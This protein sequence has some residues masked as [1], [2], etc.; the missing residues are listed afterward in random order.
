MPASTQFHTCLQH[1]K[2]GKISSKFLDYPLI[3]ICPIKYQNCLYIKLSHLFP[4][5][6]F[7]TSVPWPPLYQVIPPLVSP[8][9]APAVSTHSRCEESSP[10][11]L[12]SLQ[13]SA[14]ETKVK[15]Y[16]MGTIQAAQGK[17]LWRKKRIQP[18]HWHRGYH[19][20]A[21]AGWRRVHVASF[22]ALP[23]PPG[24]ARSG[25]SSKSVAC[26]SS[27]KVTWPRQG[28]H[29]RLQ[30]RVLQPGVGAPQWWPNVKIKLIWIIFQISNIL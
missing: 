22:S 28:F 21:P 2:C 15:N 16:D 1:Q 27:W 6:I 11:S 17:K 19:V 9:P 10:D 30:S 25:K 13:Q 4:P 5:L 3:S 24:L 7:Q 18:A 8:P 20:A 23:G 12:R 29:L 26:F 14:E